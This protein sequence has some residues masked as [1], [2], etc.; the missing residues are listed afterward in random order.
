MAL[1]VDL[2]ILVTCVRCKTSREF[3]E[4]DRPMPSPEDDGVTVFAD[5][6]CRCGAKRVLVRASINSQG[7]A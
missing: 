5:S 6:P 1:S 4:N 2:G 3:P 7:T